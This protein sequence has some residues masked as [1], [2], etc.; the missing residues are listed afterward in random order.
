MLQAT[1]GLVSG[2]LDLGLPRL[3]FFNLAAVMGRTNIAELFFV[4]FNFKIKPGCGSGLD[5]RN[6]RPTPSLERCL[7]CLFNL[8]FVG[9]DQLE[10]ELRIA[11][12]FLGVW[13]FVA[14]RF[15]SC[16]LTDGTLNFVTAFQI[17]GTIYFATLLACCRQQR[18]WCQ[19]GWTLVCPSFCF[20]IWLWLWAR[21]TSLNFFLLPSSLK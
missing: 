5:I 15:Y 6:G 21:Q 20:S 2:W 11:I 18:V 4:T 8:F 17:P 1:A 10:F 3:L 9:Q 12:S 7:Q 14:V 13:Q 19:A 16:T